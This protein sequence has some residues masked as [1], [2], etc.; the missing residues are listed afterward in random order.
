MKRVEMII[1]TMMMRLS[2]KIKVGVVM[3]EDDWAPHLIGCTCFYC[4]GY[5]GYR[6]TLQSTA[7]LRAVWAVKE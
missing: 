5:R 1:M 7:A 2:G 4:H 3:E 6:D